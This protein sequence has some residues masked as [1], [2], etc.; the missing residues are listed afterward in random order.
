MFN[1]LEKKILQTKTVNLGGIKYEFKRVSPADFLEKDGVPL[2]KWQVELGNELMGNKN[3]TDNLTIDKLKKQWS[4]LF[5]KAVISINGRDNNL[6][7][8]IELLIENNYFIANELYAEIAKHCLNFKKKIN[9]LNIF[10]SKPV[11]I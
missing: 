6:E 5:K 4:K 9:L 10:Q 11:S 8:L 3:G 2:S 1:R 7:V